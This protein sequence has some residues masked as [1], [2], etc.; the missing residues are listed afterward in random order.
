MR[1]AMRTTL[2]DALH[3]AGELVQAE[4]LFRKAEA[5]QKQRLPKVPFLSSLQ[6]FRFCH[7]LLSQGRYREVLERATQALKIS[8]QNRWLLVIALDKLSLG[9]AHG[10][11][12]RQEKTDNYGKAMDYLNQTVVGLRKA[13]T[14]HELPRGL[15]AR[16]AL[17]RDLKE[18]KKARADL[19]EAE[20]IAQ[21]GGMALFLIDAALES[22]RLARAEGDKKAWMKNTEK[23]LAEIAEKIAQTGYRRREA[24]LAELST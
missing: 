21:R 2:A 12:A 4:A 14:Q 19:V 20:E 15:L 7:L 22:A 6:G 24:E 13:G 17:Y 16:A 18:Y 1:E 3:N 5:M 8:K 9:H 10:L 11:Q 23:T